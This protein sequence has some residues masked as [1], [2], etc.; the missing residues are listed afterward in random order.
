MR[1][2]KIHIKNYRAIDD[3]QV[4]FGKSLSL[5]SGPN[6]SGKSTVVDAI[7]DALF[8][9]PRTEKKSVEGRA[10]QVHN[11]TAIP[12]IELEFEAGSGSN[13]VVWT[14]IKRFNRLKGSTELR[15]AGQRPLAD[16]EAADKLKQLVAGDGLAWSHLWALQGKSLDDP[17]K[18]LCL[19]SSDLIAMASSQ[20]VTAAIQSPTDSRTLEQVRQERRN[21]LTDRGDP[22]T[23]TRWHAARLDAASLKQDLDRANAEVADLQA[24]SDRLRAAF[25]QE[26]EAVDRKSTAEG[27]R[28]KAVQCKAALDLAEGTADAKQQ[29]LNAART[30]LKA[31]DECER[32]LT[33]AAANLRLLEARA[34]E[35][36]EK[37][38]AASERHERALNDASTASSRVLAAE[39]A[40]LDA[41]D[42]KRA[43]EYR[44]D[45]MAQDR[46]IQRLDTELD[47]IRDLESR[48]EQLHR[49]IGTLAAPTSA[50]L[51]ELRAI[52]Q[53]VSVADASLQSL[54][55]SIELAGSAHAVEVD[56]VELRLGQPR[57][58]TQSAEIHVDG[59]LVLRVTPGGAMNLAT[60]EAQRNQAVANRDR[61]L[62]EAGVRILAEA[63]D[64]LDRSV[65]LHGELKAVRASIGSK[66]RSEL[67]AQKG[68]ATALRAKARSKAESA[69]SSL[70]SRGAMIDDTSEH[71]E[72]VDAL[73]PLL[74]AAEEKARHC[75]SQVEELAAEERASKE[76]L[77]DAQAKLKT[78]AERLRETE[79]R[80]LT[81][82]SELRGQ[83]RA[84][85]EGP[86]RL[87][88]RATLVE[89]ISSLEKS[90]AETMTE[91]MRIELKALMETIERMDKTLEQT[92]ATRRDSAAQAAAART[93]LR[94]ANVDHDPTAHANGLKVRHAAA[95]AEEASEAR[96]AKAIDLLLSC[97]TDAQS[98]VQEQIAQ[99]LMKKAQGYLD[100]VNPMDSKAII[101]L[102]S[103]GTF[104]IRASRSGS[105]ALE[106]DQLSGGAKEQFAA[107]VRLMAAEAIATQHG[108]TIP[109]IFDDAFAFTDP[110]RVE[111]VLNM[112]HHASKSG[113]QIIVLTCNP[114]DYALLGAQE[115]RLT[116][117][118]RRATDPKPPEASDTDGEV[119]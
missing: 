72:D 57:H 41:E 112:L 12:T 80:I 116:P 31:L 10:R 109:I 110:D 19:S 56:G 37:H 105:G 107:A 65:V 81:I 89:Q 32:T 79:A 119:G 103:A 90:I 52:E 25:A 111:H 70:A 13:A 86:A 100:F 11:P 95:A 46:R 6:E 43:L 106:F 63:E 59:N 99:P 20:G 5:I 82:A 48:A 18:A 64:R 68:E 62:A 35:Q 88:R 21:L 38:A 115:I 69:R 92:E 75:E 22:K 104:H 67:A 66:N 1:L 54:T 108:E 71:A 118:L 42:L 33:D 44:L 9:E 113:L 2:I 30:D 28:K 93:L 83:E 51:A 40:K 91:T 50:Q 97:L 78:A 102:D 14:V 24:A 76:L 73:S 7:F 26:R 117:P 87:M 29:T 17:S 77:A 8:T 98:Q 74:G 96:K 114:K 58:I 4:F 55:T 36:R 3:L 23:G 34:I 53:A 47:A 101:E 49:E 27:T 94:Q 84:V 60:H 16:K 61:L 45:E 85:G 15:C 39:R